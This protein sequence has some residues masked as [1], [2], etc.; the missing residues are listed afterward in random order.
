MILFVNEPAL[1]DG[2]RC[3]LVTAGPLRVVG[4]P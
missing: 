4:R 1:L 2:K 3:N